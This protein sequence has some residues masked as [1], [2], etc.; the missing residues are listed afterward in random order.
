MKNPWKTLSVRDIYDNPWIRV[1]E[2][3]VIHPGGRP[4]IFGIVGFKNIA[5]GIVPLDESG[6]TWLVGQYRYA[7]E[8][9]SWEI[10]MG[11]S[12]LADSPLAGAQR[13]LAEE[14]GLS[15]LHWSELMRLHTSNCVTDEA[16]IVYLARE[17]TA[18]A[19]AFDDGEQ[20]EIRKLPFSE[21][22]NM[23]MSGAITDAV[24]VAGLLKTAQ[25]AAKGALP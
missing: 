9:W 16:A 10:P 1:R 19:P 2:H 3:E 20:L 6:N 21:A 22:V 23:V 18:G 5:V 17:L 15:A 4:G 12:G 13:E 8:S 11:G 7:L 24:S 14:T 25:L